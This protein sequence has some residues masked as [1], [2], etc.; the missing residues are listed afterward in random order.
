MPCESFWCVAKKKIFSRSL[1]FLL[2]SSFEFFTF[3][4]FIWYVRVRARHYEKSE[5]SE[6]VKEKSSHQFCGAMLDVDIFGV[7]FAMYVAF[8]HQLDVAKSRTCSKIVWLQ[9]VFEVQCFRPF[10][11]RFSELTHWNICCN[12][13]YIWWLHFATATATTANTPHVVHLHDYY[14][15][16]HI[17]IF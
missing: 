3:R 17:S 11:P 8:C 1:Y 10:L 12:S 4:S 13:V 2:I 5:R 9:T 7:R 6:N 16:V 14:S 15:C